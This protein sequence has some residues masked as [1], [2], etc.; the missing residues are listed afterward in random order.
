M[1]AGHVPPMKSIVSLTFGRACNGCSRHPGA[2]T[3]SPVPGAELKYFSS[4]PVSCANSSRSA[5]GSFS[6]VMFGQ[7]LA[8]SLFSFSHLNRYAAGEMARR[9]RCVNETS[10]AVRLGRVRHSGDP[11]LCALAGPCA[12]HVVNIEQRGDLTDIG[13][14]DRALLAI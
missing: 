4:F 2:R 9:P 8:N 6:R 7:V 1:P 14:L 10:C 12:G 13:F 11:A 3:Q 5:G